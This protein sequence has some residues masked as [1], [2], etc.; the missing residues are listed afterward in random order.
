MRRRRAAA[1]LPHRGKAVRHNGQVVGCGGCCHCRWARGRRR[2]ELL[3]RRDG[4]ELWSRAV[5]LVL[6]VS[7]SFYPVGSN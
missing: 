1:D 6:S 7:L 2:G 4:R 3:P 5:T